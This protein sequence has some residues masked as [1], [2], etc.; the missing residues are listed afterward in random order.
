MKNLSVK[1]KMNIILALVLALALVELFVSAK[2]LDSMKNKSLETMEDSIRENYDQ[3]IREQVENALTVLDSVNRQY[4]NGTYT[5]D[6]AKK[7]AADLIRDVRYGENGYFWIDDAQGNNIV[8]LGSET[9]GTNRMDAKDAEGFPLIREIIDVA[10]KEGGGYTDYVFP[11]E[12]ET[13]SSPKRSYSAYFEPFDWVVGTGNYT[14]YIDD[15]IAKEDKGFEDYTKQRFFTMAGT[16]AGMILLVV[17]LVIFIIIDITKAMKKVSAHIDVLADGNFA[18]EMEPS[19]K[20]RRDDFGKLA[21]TVDKMRLSVREL[22]LKV[23]NKTD[24]IEGVIHTMDQDLSSLNTAIDDVSG[25]TEVLAASTQQT[26]ASAE[27]IATMSK[28]VEAA[29]RS[30]AERAQDSALSAEDIKERANEGKDHAAKNRELV[31]NTLVSIREGLTRALKD[32]EIVGEIDKLAEMILNITDQTNLLALNASIEAARAG[33]AG[34]GFAVVADEIQK[35]AEES[36]AV[37]TNIQSVTVN[38]GAAVRNLASD[39]NSLLDFVSKDVMDS[40]HAFA[41]MADTYY[42]D[43]AG[44]NDMSADFSGATEELLSTISGIMDSINEI[45][46]ASNNGAEGTANIANKSS[47]IAQSSAQT[48]KNSKDAVNSALELKERLEDFTIH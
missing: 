28:E 15:V 44:V 29:A 1:L 17:V 47:A 2:S 43:A 19:L 27:Q 22:L 46:L 31:E 26:A 45:S 14:D 23:E 3:N 40:I 5:L 13:E 41:Q 42:K 33:D 16:L 25:T 4:E 11:K 38:V 7:V 8:L 48:L 30:I 34:R 21:A 6:E 36:K 35:L 37:V 9:E 12:G 32:A 39:S 10:V 24:A 20:R 18:K